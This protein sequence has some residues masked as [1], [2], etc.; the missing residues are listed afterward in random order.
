MPEINPDPKNDFNS[1]AKGRSPG[2][3]E[4]ET[5]QMLCLGIHNLAVGLL[6][7]DM[8]MVNLGTEQIQHAQDINKFMRPA[9]KVVSSEPE[10][11]N[12]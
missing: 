6:T 4:N 11:F 9:R 8:S 7:A 12:L 5:F 3:I 1:S 10:E 2:A